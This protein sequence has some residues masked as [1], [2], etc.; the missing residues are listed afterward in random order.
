M[1]DDLLER[2]H[3]AHAALF[4]LDGVLVDSAA[5]HMQAYERVFARSGL[6]FPDSARSLVRCGAARARVLT[7]ALGDANHPRMRELYREKE[8]TF[9]QLVSQHA[10]KPV[11]GAPAFVRT[12]KAL[13]K[14]LALVT[15]SR[16]P[17][18]SLEPL[19][20]ADCFDVIVD[21]SDVAIPK[22]HPGCYQTALA[23]LCVRPSE[24]VVFEDSAEGAAA[25]FA[26]GLSVVG[27]GERVRDEVLLHIIDFEDTRLRSLG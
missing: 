23:R 22:P 12:L 9:R 19:G 5:T 13:G 15:S 14:K 27:V 25:A 2:I 3:Q 10:L 16:A 4:D 6:A 1:R 7:D 21:A 24:G 20:L 26:A 18:V 8:H 11:P 17:T